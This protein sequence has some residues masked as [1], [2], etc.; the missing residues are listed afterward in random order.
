MNFKFKAMSRDYATEM[1]NNWKYENKYSIYDYSNEAEELLNEKNWGFG[2]FAVFNEEDMLVGELTIDFFNEVDENSED[3]G[4]VDRETVRSNPN[5]VYE[6]WVGFGLKPNLTGNG[7]GKQFVS[8]CIDF[9]VK[10]HNYKGEY[11]RLGVAEFNKRA[12][13]TY[14]KVGFQ[15]FNTYKTEIAGE[16]SSVLWM[17]KRLK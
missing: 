7:V 12:L 6:M 13:K 16:K 8:S 5:K 1:I 9:A 17:K 2:K 3:D 10:F 15:V 4:Y 11:V 14:E